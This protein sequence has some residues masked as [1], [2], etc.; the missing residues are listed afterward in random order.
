MS[1]TNIGAVVTVCEDTESIF[2]VAKILKDAGYNGTGSFNVSSVKVMLPDGTFAT[3]NTNIFGLTASGDLYVRPDLW[4]ANWNG[5]FKTAELVVDNGNG[6]TI[7]LSLQVVVTPV[8][9]APAGADKTFDLSD[10]HGVVLNQAD[11]GFHE[12]VANEHDVLK[13]V[14][15]TTLPPSGQLLLNGVALGLNAEITAADIDAGKL[16]FVPDASKGGT[17][18][19]GFEVRDTGGTAGCNAQD[20]S[21]TP[22]YLTF[23]VPLAHIGDLVWEDKNGNGL[24]DADEAGIAGVTVQLKDANGQIVATTSTDANGAYHFDVNGGTYSVAIVAPAG[25]LATTPRAGGNTGADSDID[26]T[27]HTAPVTVALGETNTTIDAGLYKAASLG[28]RVWIDSNRNGVQDAGEAGLAGVKVTLLDANGNIVGAPLVTDASGNYLFTNLPQGS[29]S[30]VFDKTTLP[31]GYVFTTANAGTDSGVDS[32]ADANGV[33]NVVLHAG[34]NNLTIDAGVAAK[35][36]TIGDRVWED[37]NH[38]GVQDAGEA[39]IAGVTVN[40]LDASGNQVGTTTTDASGNYHFSV[41]PGTYSVAVVAPAGYLATTPATGADT[42]ADSDIDANGHTAAIT[43]GAGEVNNTIDAG[44]YRTASLGDRVWIDSNKNGVQD[45]GEAGMAGVKVTLI[46]A[47]GNAVGSPLTT[48]ANGNYL[49]TNL[50]PGSYSVQFDKTTLPAGYVFTTAHAGADGV[51]D[52]DA[53]SNGLSD[54]VVLNSGDVNLSVDAGIVATPATI[55]DRVWEDSNH[56]GVQDA[57]EAGIAGV[58]VNLLDA[59]GNQVGTTTTDAS[60]NYHFS[61]A[62]GTYS[63]AVVAPAGY[64]ATTPATGAD[65]AADSDIDA[66]GHTAAITVGAGEVNNTIDAGLYRTASLGDRV[67]IDSNKNGVQDAGEAGMAGVKVTLID[68]NGNA[69]GSPLTTDANG[70]Y[71]FTNL[72]PGSYSVQFDKTTLPA[73]Y[74]FTTA[75]AG[76]DGVV[77]S[78]ADSNGLSNPV[79]LNSGDVNLSV[80]AGIVATPATIG[81]RVWEDKNGNGIQDAGDTGISNVTVQL[82]NAAGAVVATTT[83]DASG[84]YSFSVDAGTY[85]VAVVSPKGYVA[86]L[87]NAGA[88]EAADSDINAAGQSDSV[89]VT[90]GQNYKDLDAGLVKTVSIGDR[91]WLDCN[92][93]GLQD[94]GDTGVAGVKVYLLDATGRIVG[95]PVVTDANGNYVFTGLKPGTYS[96]QFDKATLPAG[97]VFTTA[98]VGS[99]DA[100]DSDANLATG[101]THSV[102]ANSGDVITSLDAGIVKAPKATIGDRVWEDKNGNGMQDAGES[103]IACVTV[104]LKDASGKVIDTT[105]TD[106]NGNYSFSVDAGTYSVA[107]VS[108]KGYVATLQNAGA[109]E[110]ADS[111]INAAGQS[112]SVTVTAGQNY[113]DLDAGLQKTVSIGDRVWVDSNGNGV[114]DRGEGGVAGVKVY[115]LDAGGRI[116]GSPVVTDASGNYVFTG[117]KPGTYSVQFDKTTLPAGYVFTT[118][119]VGSNDAIDSDAN[120]ATGITHSVTANSGDVITSLDA[121]IVKAPKATIGDRVWEDKNANGVQ[122]AGESGIAAVTVQL[123]DAAGKVVDTTTTD[124]NGNYSFSV[125]AGTYSVAVV[126]PKGYVVTTQNVGANDAADSDINAAG[127]SQSVTVAAGQNYKDLDAG[128]YQNISIGDRVWLDTNGN[129]IQDKGEGGVA[130]V[131]V[132]LLDAAGRVVGSPVVTDANGN[133]LFSGLKPGTYSVQF[134]KTTLPAGYAFTSANAGTDDSKDSDANTVTGITHSVTGSSGDAITSLDAGIVKVKGSIGDRVW[135][136][137]NFNGLQDSGESGVSGVKVNLLD[138]NGKLLATTTTAADGS[139]LFDNLAAGNYKVQVVTPTGYYYTKSNVG[140]DDKIDSDVDRTTGTTGTIALAAGQSVSSVDAGLYRKASIGDKV[141]ED[142]DHDGIQDVK[143]SGIDGI[144]VTLYNSNNVAVATTTTHDG[145]SYN[146]SNLDPGTY[147]LKFDKTNVMYHGV[148]MSTWYFG[149]KNIGADGQLDSDVTDDSAN[150]AAHGTPINVGYTD[151]TFLESGENDMSW[152]AS[153]TPIVIDLNG[154]GVHTISKDA[155][156]GKFDLLGTGSAIQSGWISSSDGFLAVDHNGNGKIDDISE[157]FGGVSKGS[158]FAKLADYDSNHDGVVDAN[159]ALFAE[160]RIWRDA[161]SNG[162]TDAG[163]L[164]TLKD[165]G[166]ASL[167]V[168]YTELPYLDANNNLH[169]ERSSATLASGNSVDMTD[170]Y[171]DVSAKDAATAGIKLPTLADLLGDDTALDT[172]LNGSAA[173]ATTATATTLSSAAA[174]AAAID[175]TVHCDVADLLRKAHAAAATLQ[176]ATQA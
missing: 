59:S 78:D 159:D 155:F 111:D 24:Q 13:S 68:A 168:S 119:N 10:A 2:S 26:S 66:N 36:A 142:K 39:G 153:I 135:E 11:F 101:I 162:V 34:D 144:K 33:A 97:Y 124:A 94:K 8:N 60:G 127:Q 17:F 136:D 121:G 4:A 22:N 160:L 41:D 131:K 86:T 30:V 90:A 61:V 85:S 12:V 108:P 48:D 51:V 118:A 88:N 35:P 55:G 158:G 96:V 46:D 70:N 84:N 173:A 7:S 167:T 166:V 170:V 81:D 95:S 83:T 82:K 164:M 115:L 125:N 65:T 172:V 146:F 53:D 134:D 116:V 43:V 112:D 137:K 117:L 21:A 44:L 14:I 129:G 3:G 71:L 23:K 77:D 52:S 98:N 174:S 165:A 54:P 63:V 171:L 126:A 105:T 130:G 145:G 25:Y 110:A 57:G 15:I 69:V 120:A 29:Y 91:V 138:A 100:I 140:S 104:Q 150:K 113:K 157:L 45:A 175:T 132:Y 38:N 19:V 79:V 149:Q 18:S 139:Y 75:H 99:N 64:L 109:N 156:T 37:S 141:W 73:G 76:A 152:D 62:P 28:D 161:N 72:A 93:N 9:D 143:E 42:A 122:D 50:A 148:N 58:T 32:D 163:E 92:G 87:Q 31:A 16:V 1:T 103:G 176:A 20:T 123:K 56:N 107:V 102:T 106:S 49:F 114:Q 147:Y 154:D 5:A 89:T 67:W 151:K 40:L 6:K 169:L 27:G 74:V 128:L 80:D 133:Y 47:N